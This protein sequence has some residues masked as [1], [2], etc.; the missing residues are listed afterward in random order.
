MTEGVP[1]QDLMRVLVKVRDLRAYAVRGGLDPWAV[2][3]GLLI[4]LELDT[5]AA[6]ERGV[7][8]QNLEKFDQVAKA[9]TQAW[10]LRVLKRG[11]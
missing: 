2:R 6:L 3:Q 4:A 11:S 10:I 9:D 7:P 1:E 5:A 8:R